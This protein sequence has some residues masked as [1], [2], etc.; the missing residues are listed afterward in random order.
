MI[1][2]QSA[3][4]LQSSF[5]DLWYT[6]VQFVP[7]IIA[8]VIIF[9][10][11]WIVGVVLYR[12]VEQVVKVLRIDEA[13][14]ATGLNEVSREAGFNLNV[15]AFLG[16]LVQWF[17]V[18]VF[19]VAAL[20]VLGLNRVTVFLQQ[21]VLYYLP[22]VIV[23]VLILILAAIVAEAVRNIIAS[24]A[25]AAGAHSGN[26]AGTVAKYAIWITAVL[27]VLNQLGVASEFV[28]TLFTGFVVALSLAFG[29][30]FGLGG[31]EAAAR[32]IERVRGE[33]MHNRG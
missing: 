33:I 23:A 12:V 32:T 1:V 13:L 18:I 11:G 25:K 5:T 2:S 22:Q 24:S 19:L 29:L 31:K 15:G 4:V 7:A 30:A 26:L 14:K 8:A 10:I 28:Q 20:D 3:S 21:V 27:A 9:I 17:V 16:T 6:V